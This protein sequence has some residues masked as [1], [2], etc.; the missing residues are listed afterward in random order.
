VLDRAEQ[1]MV[2]ELH[3]NVTEGVQVTNRKEDRSIKQ[4][5]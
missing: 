5:L 2:E 4:S 3:L 1:I